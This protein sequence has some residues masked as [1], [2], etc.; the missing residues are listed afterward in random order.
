MQNAQNNTSKNIVVIQ[1]LPACAALLVVLACA[2][3]VPGQIAFGAQADAT[4]S[5]TLV[6]GE[7]AATNADTATTGTLATQAEAGFGVTWNLSNEGVLTISPV[8]GA[9]GS[10]K[11]GLG[12]QSH[13]AAMSESD[14]A[15]WF[16]QRLSIKKVVIGAGITEIGSYAFDQC[17]NLDSASI[18][19]SVRLIGEGAFF[20]CKLSTIAI[21]NGVQRIGNFA[22]S[23]CEFS[24][25]TIPASVTSIG[26]NAFA[27]YSDKLDPVTFLGDAPAY[28]ADDDFMMETSGNN[29][30]ENVTATAYYPAGNSTWT[31]AAKSKLSGTG[32][33]AGILKWRARNADGSV[34]K[35]AITSCTVK[36]SKTKIAFKG[37]AVKPSVTVYDQNYKMKNGTD[38]SISIKNNTKVGKASV[39]ITG[40]GEYAGSATKTFKIVKGA[41]PLIVK[42]KTVNVAYSKLRAKNQS[43]S[44]SKA[45]GIAKAQGALTCKKVSGNAKIKVS[46]TGKVI[47]G[48]GLA[49]GSYKI[50]V[51]VTASG[52]SNYK[53]VTKTVKLTIRV[54]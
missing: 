13:L 4:G 43:V 34:R 2:L 45:F 39:V 18:P 17:A 23:G 28:S 11:I 52:N 49:K 7:V 12:W 22:F 24:S 35:V 9:S 19:S 21:P 16:S 5:G 31:S 27:V 47:V 25:V 32:S 30:F 36:L 6:A 48:R 10:A 40:K 38:Y 46:K 51:K 8:A 41:N 53:S 20:G 3:L 14:Q 54:K 44:A 37:S 15:P 33:N 1:L 50:K 29:P 26:A 42:S